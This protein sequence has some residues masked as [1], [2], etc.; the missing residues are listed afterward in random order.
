MPLLLG[1]TAHHITARSW[2]SNM[3]P[4]SND[5]SIPQTHTPN[6]KPVEQALNYRHITRARSRRCHRRQRTERLPISDA[7][8]KAMFGRSTG[9][10][11]R[12]LANP[13]GLNRQT[14]AQEPASRWALSCGTPCCGTLNSVPLRSRDGALAR[15][16]ASRTTEPRG[17]RWT[18]R[19]LRHPSNR[20]RQRP[21][22]AHSKVCPDPTRCERRLKP[23]KWDRRRR[24]CLPTVTRAS[25][26]ALRRSRAIASSCAAA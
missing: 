16:G 10:G 20:D 9:K 15:R 1:I 18:T 25:P 13:H 19:R 14:W 12:S 7:P 4:S 3:T 23:L 22:A 8:P 17:A 2:R 6:P 11:P 21:A 24:A 5:V 26:G